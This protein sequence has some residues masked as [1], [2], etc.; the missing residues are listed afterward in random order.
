MK[1]EAPKERK[2][3]EQTEIWKQV[4]KQKHIVD[5]YTGSDFTETNYDKYGVL[6]IDHSYHGASYFMIRCG[7]CYRP[8][9]TLIARKVITCFLI[10]YILISFVKFSMKPFAL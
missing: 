10:I 9:R 4:I 6:S 1:L 3:K 8:L 5:L 7:M 2:L